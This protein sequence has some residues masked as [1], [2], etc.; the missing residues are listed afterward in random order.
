M[1]EKVEKLTWQKIRELP[2]NLETTRELGL[3]VNPKSKIHK[4]LL[5]QMPV[6]CARYIEET[7][8]NS[9]LDW[10]P[11]Y[12]VQLVREA[13]SATEETAPLS[14]IKPASPNNDIDG[15]WLNVQD[16]DDLTDWNISDVLV[17]K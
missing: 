10:L 1:P 4:Y 3:Q 16:S 15:E 6:M 12:F 13:L 2:L 17:A 9:D 5:E 7:G 14:E 11:G 8:D